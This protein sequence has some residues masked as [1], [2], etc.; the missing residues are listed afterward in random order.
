EPSYRT[1]PALFTEDGVHPSD[2]GY[3]VLAR[4]LAPAVKRVAGL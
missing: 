1:D 3:S 2:G 4:L